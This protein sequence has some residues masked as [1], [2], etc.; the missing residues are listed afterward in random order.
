MLRCCCRF[1]IGFIYCGSNSLHSF[2]ILGFNFFL[3]IFTICVGQ[4]AIERAHAAWLEGKID[5]TGVMIHNVISEVDMGAPIVVR[6]IPFIKGADD[7]VNAFE[8]KV[9][10]VE[11]ETVIEGVGIAIGEVKQQQQR[12]KS[13][14]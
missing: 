12:E 10:Q 11:W 8:N 13:H 1:Y 6:E 4:N 7:D 5:K 3:L 14:P 9:H 2:F